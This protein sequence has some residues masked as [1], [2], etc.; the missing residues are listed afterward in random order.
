[1]KR[2]ASEASEAVGTS[3]LVG[4]PAEPADRRANEN[5]EMNVSLS[6]EEVRELLPEYAEPGPRPAGDVEVHLASCAACTAELAAYRDL[7]GG[8]AAYA[9]IEEEPPVGYLER[10]LGVV[11]RASRARAAIDEL[12]DVSGRVATTVRKRPACW[13][14]PRRA[15]SSSSRWWRCKIWC[16]RSRP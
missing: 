5:G 3:C 15:R 1:M 4:T 6:C 10:T 13:R 9:E 12:R 8:L 16:G 11:P 2:R 7:L 14:S